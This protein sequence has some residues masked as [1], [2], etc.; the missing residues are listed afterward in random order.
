MAQFADKTM[1]RGGL[2]GENISRSRLSR[3]L[4]IFCN[5]DGRKLDFSHIDTALIPD[6]D[7]RAQVASLRAAG[8][9][10]VTVTHPF[11]TDADALADTRDGYP[12]D[13]GA[14][15]LLRFEPGGLRAVN[16]D[17]TGMLGAWDA[18]FGDRSPGRVAVAGAGGVARAIVAALIVRGATRIDIWDQI[19]SRARALAA[20]ADPGGGIVH[21]VGYSEISGPIA[22]ADG[23]V[24]ATPLGMREYP[25]MA[26]HPDDFAGRT[27]AFDAVYTPVNTKFI[28]SAK[29]AGLQTLSGFELFRHMAIGSYGAYTDT[30]PVAGGIGLLASLGEGL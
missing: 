4:E 18:E 26:F 27:W 25:G 16:T 7:F 5:R 15:N 8:F 9:D 2:I 24:N 3:A 29:W 22:C 10:G 12:A 19:S 13:L 1:L 6:F 30:K 23:L 20:G 28:Q 14:A 11:K 17:F 21:P